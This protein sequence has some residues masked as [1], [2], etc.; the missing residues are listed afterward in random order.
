MSR[1]VKYDGISFDADYAASISEAAFIDLFKNHQHMDAWPNLTQEGREQ[2]LATVHKMSVDMAKQPV[3]IPLNTTDNGSTGNESTGEVS[4]DGHNKSD[5]GSGE[6]E[7]E[8]GAGPQ[9]EATT[10]R[11][12]KGRQASESEVQ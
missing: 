9:P 8:Q 3:I 6:R 1:E 7:S 10:K 4:A 11:T 5:S 12:G 2:T